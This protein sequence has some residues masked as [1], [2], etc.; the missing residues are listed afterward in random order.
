MFIV[1]DATEATGAQ[2]NGPSEFICTKPT[3]Q[4]GK[5][6]NKS[7]YRCLVRI[8]E[9]KIAHTVA[10]TFPRT[11]GKKN[12]FPLGPAK[13]E[14][15]DHEKAGE[16]FVRAVQDEGHARTMTVLADALQTGAVLKANAVLAVQLYNLAAEG[17][18]IHAMNKLALILQQGTVG[19]EADPERAVELNN[20]A[21]EVDAN[22][23]AMIKLAN[24][25]RH[26]GEGVEANPVRAVE[27]LTRAISEGGDVHAMT[28]IAYLL[29]TGAGG[30]EANPARA[31]ELYNRAIKGS[32]G[33]HD[34]EAVEG[35]MKV[36]AMTKFASLVQTGANGVS[37]DPPRA[38]ELYTR[39]IEEGDYVNAMK[40]LARLVRADAEGISVNQARAA[41]LFDH[42][43][44]AEEHCIA[45][46]SNLV[47]GFEALVNQLD[48]DI[49]D[50]LVEYEI[51]S[52]SQDEVPRRFLECLD[53]LFLV[54]DKN[55]SDI[56]SGSEMRTTHSDACVTW[57][58]VFNH[59]QT[60]QS[61]SSGKEIN[62]SSGW[63]CASSHE[64]LEFRERESDSFII[65]LMDFVLSYDS[66][67]SL[68]GIDDDF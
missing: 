68:L 56:E 29:E 20:R 66:R 19:V 3:W 31:V 15:N 9:R 10:G 30:V 17:G 24:F 7:R 34:M 36:R 38:V 12:S 62:N 49:Q 67:K 61:S 27:L 44:R 1:G 35:G 42:A 39:A 60:L 8:E 33:V 23:N 51:F 28:S 6:F 45:E 55:L 41:D 57:K 40:S 47:H 65:F 58:N 25:M 52:S 21:I 13:R 53:K 59:A 18:D 16:D 14:V 22:V 43:T 54:R 4:W 11:K 26:G 2:R 63:Y 64:R 5:K 46:Y 48:S 50:P 32:P 37:A